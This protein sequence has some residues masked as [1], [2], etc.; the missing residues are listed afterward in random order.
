MGNACCWI[1]F[2]RGRAGFKA[3]GGSGGEDGTGT[4]SESDEEAT[5]GALLIEYE[6]EEYDA[7]RVRSLAAAKI[8]EFVILDN[9]GDN[10]I[11]PGLLDTVTPKEADFRIPSVLLR[12][13]S[14]PFVVL[15]GLPR[16]VNAISQ[17]REMIPVKFL[18]PS[19][20]QDC[21]I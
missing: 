7:R 2:S 19:E 21:H 6:G 3:L 8:T 4:D 16:I 14:P 17:G 5:D 1:V 12:T 9:V 11:A 10:V 15:D 20:L 18:S 13:T